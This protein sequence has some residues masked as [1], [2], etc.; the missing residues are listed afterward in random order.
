[1]YGESAEAR[2]ALQPRRMRWTRKER[3]IGNPDMKH[4]STSHVERQNLNIGS[5]MRRFTR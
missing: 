5:G 1:M 4:V 3:V 2:E